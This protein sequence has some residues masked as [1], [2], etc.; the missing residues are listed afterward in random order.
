MS[1]QF[2]AAA[3]VLLILTVLLG[4]LYPLVVTAVAG[5]AMPGRAGGSL[6][7]LGGEG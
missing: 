5:L 3:R 7:R 2:L 4:V 6:L 1:R